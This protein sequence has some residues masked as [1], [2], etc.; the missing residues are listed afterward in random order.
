MSVLQCLFK[1]ACCI[2]VNFMWMIR[3]KH[4]CP[5]FQLSCQAKKKFWCWTLE[6]FNQTL[7]KNKKTNQQKKKQK[8]N[9]TQTISVGLDNLFCCFYQSL[10]KCFS[11]GFRRLFIIILFEYAMLISL[12]LQHFTGLWPW[13][14][15][16]RWGESTTCTGLLF[17]TCWRCCCLS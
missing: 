6:T 3:L 2:Q 7:A 12:V 10:D 15:I 4:T 14:E 1:V 8:N 5:S 9:N 16:K 17:W 11:V 13:F